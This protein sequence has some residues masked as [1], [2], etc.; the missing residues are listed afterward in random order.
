MQ[1]SRGPCCC[2]WTIQTISQN[3]SLLELLHDSAYNLISM[4]LSN[5]GKFSMSL[6]NRPS[7]R[8]ISMSL[9]NRADGLNKIC[10]ARNAGTKA[11]RPGAAFGVL[12]SHRSS[13]PPPHPDSFA[14]LLG[15]HDFIAS[16]AAALG[17]L[18]RIAIEQ[19]VNS[20]G[21]QGVC[22]RGRVAGFPRTHSHGP[23]S[24]YR[25]P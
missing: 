1:G 24:F 16:T 12:R 8:S 10:C 9:S 5:R 23:L 2:V 17:C 15:C 21:M 20:G 22:G 11:L 14:R 3:C 18:S 25:R 13:P 4:S 19:R 6:S 7:A